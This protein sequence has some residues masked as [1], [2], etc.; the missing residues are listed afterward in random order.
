MEFTFRKLGYT[1]KIFAIVDGHL[2]QFEP[3]EEGSFRA[4][5]SDLHGN[6]VRPVAS[7][8]PERGLIEA[9]ILKLTQEFK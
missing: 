2:M 4:T 9:V 7:T 3:D 1:Y 6:E 5:L 8:R